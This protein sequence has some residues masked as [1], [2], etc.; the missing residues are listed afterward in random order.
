MAERYNRQR[1][2]TWWKQEVL[3]QARI[4]IPG[5]GTVG[6]EECRILALLGVEHL[7]VLD[8]GKVEEANLGTS[9]L[10]R[11]ED[12]GKY[13]ALV[14]AQ[15]IKEINPSVEVTAI[16]GDVIHDFGSANYR[17]FKVCLDGLDMREPRLVLSKYCCFSNVPLITGGMDG[18][19]FEVFTVIPHHTPCLAC[20]FS[21]DDF[22]AIR[23]RYSC[24]GLLATAPEGYV[25]MVSTTASIM[26]GFAV[27]EAL[28]LLHGKPPLFAGKKLWMDGSTGEI[29]IFSLQQNDLCTGHW[30]MK[31][32]DIIQLPFS[33]STTVKEIRVKVERILGTSDFEIRHDKSILYGVRCLTCGTKKEFLCP[34]GKVN[35]K[36]TICKKCSKPMLPDLSAVLRYGNKTLGEYG[37]PDKH[38]L[39]VRMGLAEK[40]LVPSR[41]TEQGM[42]DG[43][44]VC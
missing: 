9:V 11:K 13:K 19:A 40:Y 29:E 32:E 16:V 4:F 31:P 17:D 5:I 18:L 24:S 33:N 14:A 30:T 7:T 38:I 36:E 43:T 25:P 2:L 35:E 34:A 12:I 6:N 42:E 44:G 23:Q 3:K 28:F 20:G 10:F 27:Q 1:R 41:P 26:A 15:R 37:I 8:W 39:I 22:K 21:S